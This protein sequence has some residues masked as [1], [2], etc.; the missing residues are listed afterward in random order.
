M[1]GLPA[2]NDEANATSRAAEIAHFIMGVLLLTP[3]AT[4]GR[5]A[6]SS[7]HVREGPAANLRRFLLLSKRD[8]VASPMSDVARDPEC[9]CR[10]AEVPIQGRLQGPSLRGD[11]DP[12]SRLLVMCVNQDLRTAYRAE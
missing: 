12:V 5:S 3:G 9:P 4:S 6:G 7:P 1:V 8:E 11:T 2:S 10:A